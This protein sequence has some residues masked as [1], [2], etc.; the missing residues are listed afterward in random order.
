MRLKKYYL[1]VFTK[2]YD[3]IAII[4]LNFLKIPLPTTKISL[5]LF[6]WWILGEENSQLSLMHA[7][8]FCTVLWQGSIVTY[9]MII[10]R[11]QRAGIM[12]DKMVRK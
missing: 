4:A 11:I 12:Y 10:D 8:V 6:R 3:C 9:Q 1:I 2:G 5:S 7:D